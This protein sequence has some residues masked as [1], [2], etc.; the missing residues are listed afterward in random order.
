MVR[1]TVGR[2]QENRRQ[3]PK[4]CLKALGNMSRKFVLG[5]IAGVAGVALVVPT[6]GATNAVPRGIRI[7]AWARHEHIHIT[8]PTTTTPASTSQPL[9]GETAKYK[10]QGGVVQHNPKVYV[11]FWGSNFKTAPS[12]WSE[13]RLFYGD[14]E[15]GGEPAVESWQK[16]DT[17]YVDSTGPP[18]PVSKWAGEWDAF[19]EAAPQNLTPARV[20]AKVD[21]Y[22]ANGYATN[23]ESFKYGTIEVTPDSQFVVIV[24]RETTYKEREFAGLCGYHGVH[25]GY[26]FAFVAYGGSKTECE[27][28][29]TDGPSRH[30]TVVAGHEFAEAV[31]DPGTGTGLNGWSTKSAK[32]EEETGLQ[33]EEV[34]DLCVSEGEFELPTKGSIK[35]FFH[36]QKLYDRKKGTCSLEDPPYPPPPPPAVTSEGA[37]GIQAT[38][39]TL[40][41]AINPNGPDAHYYFEYGTTT[42]YGQTTPAPPGNDLGYG[43][44]PLPATALASGLQPGTTYHY[45]VVASSWAGTS[46]G[47]D[48]TL[49]TRGWT[50]QTTVNPH[51]LLEDA[52]FGG[53]SCW[54]PGACTA[55]GEYGNSEGR[56]VSLV[57]QWNGTTWEV[58]T[59][60]NPTPS[61][62]VGLESASCRSASECTATGYYEK[63][64]GQTRYSLAERWNGSSW[65]VQKTP[66]KGHESN[67]VSVSCASSTECVAGGYYVVSGTPPSSYLLV[68]VWNGTEWKVKLG[69][70]LPEEDTAPEFRSVSCSAAKSC[71]AVGAVFGGVEGTRSL[72]ESWNGTSWKLISPPRPPHSIEDA[73]EGVSCASSTACTAVG[74]FNNTEVPLGEHCCNHHGEEA[75]VEHW[76]GTAW[77]VEGAASPLGKPQDENQSHWA[78]SKVSCASATACVAVG[79]Y[80]AD[81]EGKNVVLLGEQWNGTSWE[82][83]SPFDRTG[84]EYDTLGAVSCSAPTTCTTVGYTKKSIGNETTLAERLEEH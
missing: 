79:S 55:V 44:S 80:A 10:F 78:L 9:I 41:A 43:E 26:A 76:N 36:V 21:E 20:T 18:S 38:Q 61:E 7:P 45:R 4:A 42:A 62:A 3:E 67:L 69:A 8:P 74:H 73:L 50:I 22:I 23:T 60:P 51:G 25:N 27:G 1:R 75:L 52:R 83:E 49:R 34:A 5:C 13:L 66:T 48:S 59:S 24:A 30:T 28:E 29:G 70:K 12:P 58:Q 68:E 31:T 54:G 77:Q 81:S 46:Y 40:T 35:G 11:I 15:S 53:V 57:E 33:G 2:F 32:E 64:V 19:T 37:S 16:I 71:I 14:L 84:V 63:E 82:V 17:Q 47:A 65:S 39:A 56:L 6:A 72:A